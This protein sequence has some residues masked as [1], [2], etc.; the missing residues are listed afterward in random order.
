M[1]IVFSERTGAKK[2][3]PNT[4]GFNSADASFKKR[5]HIEFVGHLEPGHQDTLNYGSLGESIKFLES[6]GKKNIEE[7][8]D[9]LTLKAK[10]AFE[11]L[12]L[13]DSMVSSR[14]N[15]ST[16][17]NIKGDATLFDKL[18]NNGIIASLRGKGIRVS[19]HI[20]NIE[21]DIE[22]LVTVLKNH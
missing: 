15:H 7:Y 18:K 1:W 16:I 14:K 6:M 5:D 4:I 17:F 22:N 21:E 8:L 3:F 10:I 9:K 19:F 13:L 11:E 12:D 2:I 20:Y